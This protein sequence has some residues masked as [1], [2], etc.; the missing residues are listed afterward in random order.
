M[1]RLAAWFGASTNREFRFTALRGNGRPMATAPVSAFTVPPSP[2]AI[3]DTKK[4]RLRKFAGASDSYQYP[5]KARFGSARLG[6]EAP[7]QSGVPCGHRSDLYRPLT[8]HP[9]DEATVQA[10]MN[11][12]EL[13]IHLPRHAAR[14]QPNQS[15]CSAAAVVSACGVDRDGGMLRASPQAAM[16]NISILATLRDKILHSRANPRGYPAPSFREVC[17]MGPQCVDA[18]HAGRRQAAIL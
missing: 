8:G 1:Q 14:A 6:D 16:R 5:A 4:P 3:R 9:G 7:P 13:P 2:S 18:C 17:L 10:A 11:K 15:K 12:P